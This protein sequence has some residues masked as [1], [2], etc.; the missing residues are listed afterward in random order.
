MSKYDT[1]TFITFIMLV[2][3]IYYQNYVIT[4]YYFCYF[5]YIGKICTDIPNNSCIK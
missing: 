1:S 3:K 5:Y 4:F 2:I